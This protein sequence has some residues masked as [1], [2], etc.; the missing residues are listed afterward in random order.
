[1]RNLYSEQVRLLVQ[2]LPTI[3]RELAFALKGG[4]GINLSTAIC[5]G[6]PSIST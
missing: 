4:T 1:M 2:S 5:R 3:A 6:Y